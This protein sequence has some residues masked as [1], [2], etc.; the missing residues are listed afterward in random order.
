MRIAVCVKQVP[1]TES[2]IRLSGD[3]NQIDT[4]GIKWIMNPYDEHAVEEAIKIRDANAGSTIQVFT[5]GPKSRAAEVLRTALA[6]WA[7][8]RA[9]LLMRQ[10]LQTTI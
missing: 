2:K 4:T 6:R 10:K 7:P 9:Y 5:A 1:D 8:M 3:G